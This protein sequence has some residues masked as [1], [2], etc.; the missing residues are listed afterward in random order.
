MQ[1]VN[2]SP[3]PSVSVSLEN[4]VVS[5]SLK[6]YVMAAFKSFDEWC[7]AQKACFRFLLQLLY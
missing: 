3:D 2:I 6:N 4:S 5:V 7:A 1:V